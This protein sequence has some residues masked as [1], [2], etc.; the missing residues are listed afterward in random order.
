MNLRHRACD[1]NWMQRLADMAG[2]QAAILST[3][4][5]GG[6]CFVCIQGIAVIGCAHLA[7]VSR[8]SAGY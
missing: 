1:Y 5:I 2:L 8:E 6:G 4:P 7:R 3:W